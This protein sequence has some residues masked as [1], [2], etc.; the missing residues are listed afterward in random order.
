MSTQ[1]WHKLRHAANEVIDHAEADRWTASCP[2]KSAS[3][4][5]GGHPPIG[6][7]RFQH[8]SIASDHFRVRLVP[9]YTHVNDRKIGLPAQEVGV[10]A[11][12][13]QGEVLVGPTVK[14]V[15]IST[16]PANPYRHVARRDRATSYDPGEA[17]GAVV[18]R[19]VVRG[20][21]GAP[22][23]RVGPTTSPTRPTWRSH[24]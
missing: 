8:L 15:D 24:E 9:I 23:E 21:S 4:A 2:S 20:C 16:S 12:P 17:G 3:A 19:R 5:C 7:D 1:P 6:Y 13:R 10:A 18:V 14:M 11:H 22:T